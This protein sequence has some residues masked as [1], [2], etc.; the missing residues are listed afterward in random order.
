MIDEI[1]RIPAREREMLL[2]ALQ[3][4]TIHGVPCYKIRTGR[5]L[6]SMDGAYHD[7]MLYAPVTLLSIVATTNVGIGFDVEEDCA[8]GAERWVARFVRFD[9]K[10]FLKVL[11]SHLRKRDFSSGLAKQFLT[12][13]KGLE[14]AHKDNQLGGSLTLRTAVRIVENAFDEEDFGPTIKEVGEVWVEANATGEP[15][16]EQLVA[17]TT[18]ITEA[19]FALN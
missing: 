2:T 17:L 12:L 16:P 14:N 8:A 5:P 7:E 3:P 9:E 11:K 1:Y 13:Y 15:L 18:I 19:G 4:E 6:Q 10:K